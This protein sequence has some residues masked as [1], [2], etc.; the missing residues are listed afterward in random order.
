MHLSSGHDDTAPVIWVDTQ[1][2]VRGLG[3]VLR[4]FECFG[5]PARAR[6]LAELEGR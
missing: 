3:R 2:P 5:S 4:L 1:P 6:K